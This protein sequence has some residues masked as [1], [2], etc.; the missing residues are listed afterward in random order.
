MGISALQQIY[1]C[2]CLVTLLQKGYNLKQVNFCCRKSTFESKTDSLFAEYLM[3]NLKGVS[4]AVCKQNKSPKTRNMASKAVN[5]DGWSQHIKTRALEWHSMDDV[6]QFDLKRARVEKPLY[7]K[8]AQVQS[9]STRV[10]TEY[11][12]INGLLIS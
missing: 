5:M 8:D 12:C 10:N 11:Y 1:G 3:L 2:F 4:L 9:G 6:A 7:C